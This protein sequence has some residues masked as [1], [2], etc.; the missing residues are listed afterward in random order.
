M[1]FFTHI[2]VPAHAQ[3]FP[4]G[5]HIRTQCDTQLLAN[6]MSQNASP[7]GQK[8]DLGSY[9]SWKYH[10]VLAHT[11]THYISRT[12]W[13]GFSPQQAVNDIKRM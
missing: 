12:Q 11:Y 4:A 1:R 3:N 6:H 9:A 8:A 2:F 10:M 5:T 7:G 13:S